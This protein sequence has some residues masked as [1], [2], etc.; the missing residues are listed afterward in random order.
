MQS[1]GTLAETPLRSLL[2]AAQGERS[3]GTLTLR[4]GS[5]ESTSLYFLFGHLFHA[6][7]PSGQG[8]DVVI[9]ALGWWKYASRVRLSAA[10][11]TDQLD[12]AARVGGLAG[13]DLGQ[14][15]LR[16]SCFEE[17]KL[18]HRPVVITGGG[19]LDV[20][21]DRHQPLLK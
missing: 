13:L 10:V 11:I 15:V 5:G 6:S 12:V 2:E 17:G 8:E 4:N 7:G 18:P 20:F 14:H 16:R 9:G 21:D 1:H 3:T 19:L